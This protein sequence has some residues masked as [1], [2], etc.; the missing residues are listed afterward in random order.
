VLRVRP[1]PFGRPAAS[2]LRQLISDIKADDPLVPVTVLVP[3]N[4]VGVSVRRQ[5]AA[6]DLGAVT[7]AGVG[8]VGIDL[9]TPYRMA[10]LFG[11]PALAAS[12]RRPV[13]NPVVA[14]AVRG[15]L[16]ADPGLFAGVLEH[17]S[18]EKSLVRLH[19]ELR[20]LNDEQL[21][22]LVTG[23][24]R[25]ADVIR[26]H[27]AVDVSLH[28]EWYDEF[29]LMTSA[30]NA[31]AAHPALL[32]ERGHIVLY[33]PQD[34]TLNAAAML[35][36]AADHVDL[37]VLAGVVGVPKAD[38]S[39]AEVC[40]RLGGSLPSVALDPAIASH[41]V[42]AS[43]ADDEVRTVVRHLVDALREG[44]SL[45]RMAVLYGSD[46][47]YGRLLDEQLR[48]AGI[49]RNGDAVRTLAETLVGRTL[50]ALLSLPDHAFRRADVL[51]LLASAPIR[52]RDDQAGLTPVNAWERVARRAGV[53]GGLD[54][55][56][57]RLGQLITDHRADLH[58]LNMHDPES[59]RLGSLTREINQANQLLAFVTELADRLSSSMV[60]KQWSEIGVW[61][62]V[63]LDRYLG[64]VGSRNEWPKIEIEAAERIDA[65]LD[66]LAGLDE[67]E[68]ATSL[69]VFRRT[70]EL[71]LESGLGRIGSLGE[72]LFVGRVGQA[73]GLDLDR[74][75][76]LGMAEGTFPSRRS[77]DSLLPDAE[78]ASLG[79]ALAQRSNDVNND[80]R[81]FLAALSSAAQSSVLFFPRGD[82]RR[83][84]ERVHSRW[85]LDSA[86]RL[87]GT[88]RQPA[89]LH[90]DAHDPAVDWISEVPSFVAG[91]RR[92]EF[93]A[94]TQ[95][96]DL[97]S[98]LSHTE[99]NGRPESHPLAEASRA[100]ARGIELISGRSSSAF[101]RFDGNL[102]EVVTQSGVRTDVVSP[103][104]L[105]GWA[106]CP[107]R[108]LFQDVLRVSP[109]ERPDEVLRI[110]PLDHGSLVHTVLDRFVAERLDAEAQGDVWSDATA[111]RK[112]LA[113]GE[114]ECD[115][116]EARGQVGRAIFWRRDR[117][118]ILTDL[119]M[120]LEQDQLR[121]IRG[122]IVQSE[123]GFGVDGAQIRAV[124]LE[125]SNG[126]VVH[127][128][129]SIDRVE[130]TAD[131]RI[132][133]IDYKTGNARRFSGLSEDDPD[134]RGT[135]LQLPVYG[136]A[137]RQA[138]R[139]PDASVHA[140]YWFITEEPG[141]WKWVGLDIN[142]QV[143]TRF[144]EVVSL[145]LDGVNGG[146]FPPHP[147][148]QENTAYTECHYCDP[149]GLGT[150]DLRTQW[151]RKRLDPKVAIYTGLAE[152]EAILDV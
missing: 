63:L 84:S 101:T 116:V 61:A 86:E 9:L 114:E 144:D 82:L 44:V 130:R 94:T 120:L 20:D 25:A 4:Y 37:T 129:G 124:P 1:T 89:D 49:V 117:R 17:P 125:L 28:D 60:P 85:L 57:R 27:R 107:H 122:E 59:P 41:I 73:L 29:D 54:E 6:G 10:E 152:P 143:M 104:R 141:G 56:H 33:L 111:E 8:L 74:V 79:G 16:A 24:D 72:G 131:G 80:H 97:A 75:F 90:A 147:S 91:I 78:R 128:R 38:A 39:T 22:T 98:L 139:S 62:R 149:D 96:Y 99:N 40:R 102:A 43:D 121:E 51:G 93:P 126:R 42:S 67:V 77:D 34:I 132:I 7:S 87:A 137:A 119:V 47:P 26:I 92:T 15:V 48:A 58:H 88:R 50:V 23:G 110:S 118:V 46:E 14:A 19:R 3:T 145:I 66:R 113:L 136:H 150:R 31:F 55:W 36:A 140:A 151:M 21:D 52:Q 134:K 148:P 146:V 95:E 12:G 105:E 123:L 5:L 18:T 2:R 76:I 142:E 112:L 71:E 103:T 106:S 133:V 30:I 13:S 11:A 32:I 65:A 109:V 127:F 64:P 81:L 83:S 45:E 53:V 135:K 68:D 138:L 70:L 100:Y 108:Y 69:T 35:S 115:R